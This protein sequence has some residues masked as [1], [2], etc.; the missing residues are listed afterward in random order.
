MDIIHLWTH[1]SDSKVETGTP[2]ASTYFATRWYRAP[3]VILQ[4]G[5]HSGAIDIFSSGCVFAEMLLLRPLFPGE[6]ELDMLK[7]FCEILGDP[8]DDWPEGIKAAATVNFKFPQVLRVPFE[9]F[10][11]DE[12]AIELLKDMINW[13]PNRR[14]TADSCINKYSFFDTFE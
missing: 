8:S 1:Y 5:F 10:L 7:R 3:E 6:N 14:P 2:I 9:D 13:N 12:A 11:Q 4:T